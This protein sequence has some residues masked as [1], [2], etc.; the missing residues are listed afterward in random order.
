MSNRWR[1]SGSFGCPRLVT[2]WRPGAFV[3]SAA[4][5]V[6]ILLR[7]TMRAGVGRRSCR[8]CSR[9]FHPTRSCSG[10]WASIDR[11]VRCLFFA[12]RCCGALLRGAVAGRCCGALLTAGLRPRL[13]PVARLRRAFPVSS[14]VG[15]LNSGLI[16][17]KKNSLRQSLLPVARLR[18][19]FPIDPS[20][21]MSFRRTIASTRGQR[22]TESESVRKDSG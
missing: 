22:L 20:G 13:L 1:S 9:R 12:G 6:P 11:S 18:R 14:K 3:S 21:T 10:G 5:F 17:F 4:R 19:A 15:R 7:F 2:C 16:E 8:R